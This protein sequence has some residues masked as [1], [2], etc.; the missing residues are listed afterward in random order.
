MQ[1]VFSVALLIIVLH[2][3][4]SEAVIRH[5]AT[6]DHAFFM[7][8]N[9]TTE[10]EMNGVPYTLP[11]VFTGV[12][13]DHFFGWTQDLREIVFAPSQIGGVFDE[14]YRLRNE[15]TGENEY[16]LVVW[17]T[18]SD[19]LFY[20]RV[21]YCDLMAP[22]ILSHARYTCDCGL[23]VRENG[24]SL[25]TQ[26]EYT[27]PHRDPVADYHTDYFAASGTAGACCVDFTVPVLPSGQSVMIPRS[28]GATRTRIIDILQKPEIVNVIVVLFLTIM[29]AA[30][31][32]Y[33]VELLS[34]NGK[35]TSITSFPRDMQRSVWW[36]GSTVSGQGSKRPMS[37]VG[38]VWAFLM[39]LGSIIVVATFTATATSF[40]TEEALTHSI[41]T[42]D[43][44]AGLRIC[45]V[46]VLV[47]KEMREA[48]IQVVTRPSLQDCLD[49]LEAGRI[50]GVSYDLPNLRY[51]MNTAKG[52]YRVTQIFSTFD[53]AWAITKDEPELKRSLDTSILDLTGGDRES[54]WQSLQ[55]EWFGSDSLRIEFEV[56]DVD[57]PIYWFNV[58]IL[59]GFTSI[60][61]IATLSLP[62]YY[63][64]Q[65]KLNKRERGAEPVPTREG[66][67]KKGSSSVQLTSRERER[68]RDDSHS[69][70]LLF[71]SG[72]DVPSSTVQIS[73]DQE[74]F[75]IALMKQLH[76]MAKQIDK[77][78][79]I[80]KKL[81]EDME[82][83]N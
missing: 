27:L 50:D 36:S 32:Y 69:N 9:S 51:Y 5:C 22:L 66:D 58:Y 35:F 31:F 8:S 33:L 44:M 54:T 7:Y 28:L 42:L 37:I 49:L 62:L 14:M 39:F 79:Q 4:G 13:I 11:H 61:V 21:G 68:E 23:P 26:E 29:G 73:S 65:Q 3:S 67:L 78:S 80:L 1:R 40:M 16:E 82:F 20:T 10:F 57:T 6:P 81:Q 38:Q 24:S 43:D 46:P 30:F 63:M 64:Y 83:Q 12:D 2:V 60:Y 47:S 76:R 55:I 74:Q 18:Y 48:P 52:K 25:A 70:S 77:N 45:T 17:P 72:E 71:G 34:P 75:Q 53:I 41:N 19:G 56:G 59:I 15:T